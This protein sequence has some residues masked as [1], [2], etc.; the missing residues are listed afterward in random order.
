MV[1]HQAGNL[2]QQAGDVW[3]AASAT[4]PG[5]TPF[6]SEVKRLQSVRLQRI[7]IKESIPGQVDPRQSTVEQSTFEHV[8]IASIMPGTEHAVIEQ[9]IGDRRTSLVIRIFVRQAVR[10]T[11]TLQPTDGSKAA[12]QS[13]ARANQVLPDRIQRYAVML[14]PAQSVHVGHPRIDIGGANGMAHRLVLL[15]Q[16]DMFLALAQIASEMGGR[17]GSADRDETLRH[18]QIKRIAG[19]PE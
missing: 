14:R 11:E 9:H 16:G 6:L 7:D 1:I 15:P 2:H 13:D 18:P 19:L 3:R 12:G 17:I 10:R 5:G 4:E 8:E